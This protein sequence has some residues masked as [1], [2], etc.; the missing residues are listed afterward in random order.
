MGGF[1]YLPYDGAL[2]SSETVLGKELMKH[3]RKPDWTPEKNPY[4]KMLYRAQHRPDGKRSVGEIDGR[5]CV[6]SG[7][8][9]QPDTA[10]QW[11]A[12]CQLTVKD[13]AE[14]QRA[15][16][17]GWRETPGEALEYLKARDDKVAD[18]TAERHFTDARM[19]EQAQREAAEADH[20]TLRHIP[21]LGSAADRK[22]LKDRRRAS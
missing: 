10:E 13:E 9:V 15:M 22:R 21:D 5:L 17:N 14:H 11:T 18:A 12:R 7:H 16:E 2:V 8:P 3:E 20:Q 6:P 19:S 4:P 1:R